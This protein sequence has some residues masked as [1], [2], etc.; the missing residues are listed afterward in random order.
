MSLSFPYIIFIS[1]NCL[2]VGNQIYA[3]AYLGRNFE[4]LKMQENYSDIFNENLHDSDYNTLMR[5]FRKYD[6]V[7]IFVEKI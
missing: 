4:E 1:E 5:I 2:A 7:I 6:T 3:V